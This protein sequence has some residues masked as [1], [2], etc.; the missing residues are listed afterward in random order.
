MRK[1]AIVI[2]SR[3]NYGRIKSVL[4]AVN[5]HPDLELHIVVGA[6]A[7]LEEY[8]NV[9]K[10][11]EADGFV[12]SER[13]YSQVSGDLPISM[14][15]TCGLAIIE[16]TDVWARLKPDVVLTV[17]DRYETLATAISAAYMNIPVAHTQG[18]EQTGSID[19]SVRHAV[20]KLSHLH[21]PSTQ[22]AGL[23][24]ALMGENIK[25]IH[26]TGCPSLDLLD[27]LPEFI[28]VD[29]NSVGK[30]ALLDFMKSYLVVCLH[31]VTTDYENAG[32]ETIE[33]LS[34]VLK[35]KIPAV[36]IGSNVD[37]GSDTAS[38]ILRT[39]HE[40]RPEATIRFIRSLPP[41]TYGALIR[42]CA[43]LVGNSSS[44]IREGSYLGVP[45]VDIGKRQQNRE[46]ADNVLYAPNNELVDAIEHQ[47]EHGKYPKR[48]LYGE[49]DAGKKI[50]DILATHVFKIQKE[51]SYE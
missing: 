44:G 33:I 46:V 23:N 3:A 37:A 5:K 20:T 35:T 7:L 1:I 16:L 12:V 19:E 4:T 21:F 6:S 41:E 51:L 24:L 26:V 45:V 22:K 27:D 39:H 13:V 49:G 50:A 48:T 29:I 8:G 38:K 36:W 32:S 34:A 2:N 18:G 28:N 31:P 43:C 9:A 17:A 14:A 25:D 42:D 40:L 47:V 11:I 10:V 30:G 15:K